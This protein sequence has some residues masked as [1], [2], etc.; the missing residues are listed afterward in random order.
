MA[1]ATLERPAPT[2]ASHP[3][4]CYGAGTNIVCGSHLSAPVEIPATA[5]D[6]QPSDTGA[7]Y[8]LARISTELRE[9]GTLA[10]NLS[11]IGPDGHIT[12]LS[13]RLPESEWL[14]NAI[15]NARTAAREAR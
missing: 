6:W 14:E 8:P 15:H 13:F 7:R 3:S 2:T 1:T 10:V 4:F 5:G 12:D 9:D 11:L